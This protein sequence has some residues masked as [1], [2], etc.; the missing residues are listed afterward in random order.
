M[1][2]NPST[3][4]C[5]T[6]VGCGTCWQC[7]KRK[8]DHWVS[9]SIAE[10]SVSTKTYALTL[11]YDDNRMENPLSKT[12][13]IYRDIQLFLKTLRRKYNV[14]YICCGEQ[15][16]AKDRSHW[17]IILF[18][19]GDYPKE[20]LDKRINWKYWKHGFTY[21]QEPDYDGFAYVLKYILKDQHSITSQRSFAMSKKPPLGI[22]Y[23]YKLAQEHVDQGLTPQ[24]YIF[25]IPGIKNKYGKHRQFL[26][27]GVIRKKFMEHFYLKWKQTHKHQP[28]SD[29]FDEWQD[30]ITNLEYTDE[31]IYKQIH[32]QPVKY[33]Q[34]WEENTNSGLLDKTR[35][36]E[37]TYDNIPIYYWEHDDYEQITVITEKQTWLE[38]RKEIIKTIKDG[39]ITLSKK[40]LSEVW[41]G[42]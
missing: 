35:L 9:R 29:I 4:Q 41:N 6:L 18:F 34:P 14:R 16:S 5:G 7:V 26:M 2:I 36:V 27:H 38:R 20:P 11:T 31:E 13:L 39:S 28:T 33:I 25:K 24:S 32:Y 10:A 30:E 40:T 37:S 21:F 22:K 15:G 1:C 17:H 12:V 23:F 8:T 3:L 19:K 42:S